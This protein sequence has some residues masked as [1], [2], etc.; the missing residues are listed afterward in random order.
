MILKCLSYP[1]SILASA[2]YPFFLGYCSAAAI[3]QNLIFN[4]RERD[5]A[6]IAFWGRWSCW[7]FGVGID[8]RGKENIPQ[9][10]CLY[11]FNHAS[12]FDI[13]ALA[14][15]LPEL[16]FGA[17]IELFQIPVFGQA[18]RRLGVLP[19]ERQRREAVFRIYKAAE[20]RIRR[21]ERFALAPEGTRQLDGKLGPF[22]SGPF[23]FAINAKAPIVPVVILNAAEIL[24]KGQLFPN[25]GRWRCQIRMEILPEVKTESLSIE[26][27]PQL[28]NE[29]REKMR[30]FFEA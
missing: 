3:L 8:V 17:K 2:F 24:P 29:V 12:F 26:E 30:P 11:V 25:W 13:F 5:D 9:G 28:Q 21:G 20:E 7:L 16:R 6:M 18:M 10:G 22:K 15:T 14:A 4:S 27:R 23:I 1:R 19:I